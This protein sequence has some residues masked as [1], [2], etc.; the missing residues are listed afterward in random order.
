MTVQNHDDEDS[1]TVDNSDNDDDDDDNDNDDNT[2]QVHI[3][4]RENP[5]SHEQ[6]VNMAAAAKVDYDYNA[7]YGGGE[8]DD[9]AMNNHNGANILHLIQCGT[10][11]GGPDM[12]KRYAAP[13]FTR[14][15]R[16]QRYLCSTPPS[17]IILNLDSLGLTIID[18]QY[19]LRFW[20]DTALWTFSNVTCIF[21]SVEI[22]QRIVESWQMANQFRIF[23]DCGAGEF[24]GA[25]GDMSD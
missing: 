4:P 19:K 15:W 14:I 3:L 22:G 20:Y 25:H 16:R 23:G 2:N 6:A 7:N 21:T 11:W 1:D 8:D 5:Q 13:E 17:D 18:K 10:S 24:Y 12:T 9:D